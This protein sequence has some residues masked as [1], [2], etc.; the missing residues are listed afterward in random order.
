VAAAAFVLAAPTSPARADQ[1]ARP[2]RG[3]DIVYLP[4]RLGVP[5]IE[6]YDLANRSWLAA[7]PFPE[8]AQDIAVAPGAI[9]VLSDSRLRRL[10]LDGSLVWDVPCTALEIEVDPAGF[11]FSLDWA[12]NLVRVFAAAD[13]HAI[14]ELDL[15]AGSGFTY[16]ARGLSVAPG[17]R[18]L[19]TTKAIAGDPYVVSVSYDATGAIGGTLVS[20][21]RS[22]G[23]RTWTSPAS[24]RVIDE[25]GQVLDATTLALRDSLLSDV[26][27]L[28][29]D[30][31]NPVL[32]SDYALV[33]YGARSEPIGSYPLPDYPEVLFVRAGTAFV[34]DPTYALPP[35]PVATV[36]AIPLASVEYPPLPAP[37]EPNELVARPFPISIDAAGTISFLRLAGYPDYPS[38]ALY[39][40]SVPDGRFLPHVA[41]RQEPSVYT[42]CPALGGLLVGSGQLV[43]V[44]YG[45]EEATHWRNLPDW[46]EAIACTSHHV[47]VAAH[48]DRRRGSLTTY[49]PD[50]EPVDSI[51][52]GDPPS[53]GAYA[54]WSESRGRLYVWE[55]SGHPSDLRL[56]SYSIDE[57]GA[58]GPASTST[59]LSSYGGAILGT[60]GP[61]LVA[62]DYAYHP[63]TLARGR[64][65]DFVVAAAWHDGRFYALQNSHL[66]V[67][68]AFGQPT[69]ESAFLENAIGLFGYEGALRVPFF[70]NHALEVRTLAFDDLDGDGVPTGEDAFPGDP[71]ESSDRDGDGTGDNGDVFPD[72]AS[73]QADR[74]GD[75]V[76][77]HADPFDL[78]PTEWTD[79]DQDGRGDNG[80]EFPDDGSEWVDS[81]GDGTGDNGDFAPH[82]ATEWRDSDGDDVG[83]NTDLFPLDPLEQTDY[84]GDGIGDHGD[85]FPVGNPTLG[86][87]NLAGRERATFARL[88]SVHRNLP[89]GSLGLLANGDFSLC[90]PASGCLFG[91]YGAADAKGRRFELEV[92]PRFIPE[93]EPILEESLAFSLSR[94]FRRDV[95]LDL[96]P[97]P[98]ETR[99]FVKLDRTGKRG[100]FKAKWVFD[101]HLGNVPGPYRHLRF[102]LTWKFSPAE[103]VRP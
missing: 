11:V 7:L 18:R 45:G 33:R 59:A 73:E 103:V 54:A 32:L 56:T 19:F 25:E 46:T 61:F 15:G 72:D 92:D 49:G 1:Y 12:T 65:L 52:T 79:R 62:R 13:G 24:D 96:V 48:A 4:I 58:I 30:G 9:Y 34:F 31:A 21:R 69:T 41:L 95:T 76:G 66:D 43:V 87:V 26:N 101:A 97:R 93:I 27:D 74:D 98:A 44:P 3:G 90:A 75:G 6:R 99:T 91:R 50:G 39:R 102:A 55:D 68:D 85:P 81:D 94:A 83:D 20:P 70:A 17:V 23:S 2:V 82:D 28:A 38:P 51:E 77:D 100:V 5:R 16:V 36:A 67:F 47:V 29:F 89:G 78:D 57:H 37:E 40:W 53:F 80:D 88:G 42:D 10:H 8:P 63:E 64:F 71:T 35:G 22:G 14:D 60:E 84:D 86:L